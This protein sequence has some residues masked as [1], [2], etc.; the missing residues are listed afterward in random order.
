M[1]L[2]SSLILHETND[3][4]SVGRVGVD[5]ASSRIAGVL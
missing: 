4:F 1:Q 2:L 3:L 5:P